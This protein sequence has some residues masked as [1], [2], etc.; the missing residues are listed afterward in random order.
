MVP[1][2]VVRDGPQRRPT[3]LPSSASSLSTGNRARQRSHR[4]C[5][6]IRNCLQPALR[7][8]ENDSTNAAGA[9]AAPKSVPA[10][11]AAPIK[12]TVRLLVPRWFI[13][14]A[15]G[16]VVHTPTPTPHGTGGN[17]VAHHVLH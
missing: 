17:Y 4:S 13:T 9:D 2:P 15:S 5:E 3:L 6:P 8:T 14:I 16:S 7:R 12:R 1:M 11:T 10:A